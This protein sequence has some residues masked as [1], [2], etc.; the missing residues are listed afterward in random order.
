[1]SGRP[2]K[3]VTDVGPELEGTGRYHWALDDAP[4][5]NNSTPGTEGDDALTKKVLENLG[6][7]SA[8]RGATCRKVV[9]TIRSHDQGWGGSSSDKGRYRGSFTWFDVG[10]E[11]MVACREGKFSHARTDSALLNFIGNPETSTDEDTD[12]LDVEH[13]IVLTTR[14]ILPAIQQADELEFALLSDKTCLQKNK[15][16]INRFQDHTITWRATDD[17]HPESIEGDALEEQGRGRAS[18]TGE[19]VR[20][21]KVGDI[22]TVWAKARFPGWANI[23]T[24]VKVDVYWAV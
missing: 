4:R 2:R 11:R 20:N 22:I 15:T 21:L 24:D 19:F 18:L 7:D 9:F 8:S 6:E 3:P 5:L 23:V 1:M 13:P 17:V 10:L 12:T 16:A 14:R